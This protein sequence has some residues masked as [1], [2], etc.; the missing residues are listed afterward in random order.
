M[1]ERAKRDLSRRASTGTLGFKLVLAL[2]CAVANLAYGLSPAVASAALLPPAGTGSADGARRP[3]P[4]GQL[5]GPFTAASVRSAEVVLARSGV[6]TVADEKSR[7]PLV[8]VTG[9]VRMRFTRA[10]VQAMA[11]SAADGGGLLG[12]TLSSATPA[13]AGLAPLGYVLASWVRNEATPGAEAV[14]A[15]MGAQDWKAVASVVFPTI[16]LPLF[17]A[18]V[19]AHT[20]VHATAP[21]AALVMDEQ[22]M[23]FFDA[24]CSTVSNF[25]QS[26]LDSVFNALQLQPAAGN[27]VG[28]SIGNFFV[29]LW[30]GVVALA[31][32]VV[33]GL[34]DKVSEFIVSKIQLAAGA[35][36]VIAN[37]VSYLNPWSVQVSGIPGVVLA[38]GSGVFKAKVSTSGLSAWPSAVVDCLPAGVDL[39]PLEPANADATWAVSGPISPSSPTD[40]KI[41]PLGQGQLYFTT[42]AAPTGCSSGPA[43]PQTASA[44][45]TVQ[46]PGTS[47]LKQ[48]VINMISNSF[49]VAGSI[50]SPVVQAILEP[51]LD[52][53][54]KALS[55]LTQVNGTGYVT[56]SY[57]GPGGG[58]CTTTTAVTTTTNSGCAYV[59]PPPPCPYI[60]LA[61]IEKIYGKCVYTY[62][63]SVTTDASSIPPSCVFTFELSQ[64]VTVTFMPPAGGS[65]P[66]SGCKSTPF[67]GETRSEDIAAAAGGWAL[68]VQAF[69]GGCAEAGEV[70]QIALRHTPR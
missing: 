31:Q 33:Q 34:V 62:D 58:H 10:Q 1:T 17:A 29:T 12:A 28:A 20:P 3:I 63:Y 59:P 53:A 16:A 44:T 66:A 67:Y 46:R 69:I 4:A 52:R 65:A 24:P 8:S 9:P 27:G 15:M 14:R 64:S 5:G 21:K 60:S 19:I 22:A 70:A 43:A 7:T 56:V 35:V 26:T 40:I 39:P 48:V 42:T 13:A 55:K 41:S 32:R 6:A 36:V 54:L 45:I 11:L 61:Q 49:G 2:V 57:P 25:V 23:G 51:F 50:V 18:D 30:N 38:G 47:Q 37:I 68:L